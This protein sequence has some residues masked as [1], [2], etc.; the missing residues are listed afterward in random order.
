M[1]ELIYVN[2]KIAKNL[3]QYFYKIEKNE[4]SLKY[5]RKFD[6]H[7]IIIKWLLEIQK[8]LYCIV[9]SIFIIFIIFLLYS[10][11]F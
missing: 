9:Y 1:I 8:R 6:V 11:T 10:L 4:W 7:E 2:L 3:I 5:S